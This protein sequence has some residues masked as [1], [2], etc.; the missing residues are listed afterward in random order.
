MSVVGVGVI[1]AI[2]SCIQK[3]NTSAPV[4]AY[5]GLHKRT[6]EDLTDWAWQIVLA[7]TATKNS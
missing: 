7:V 1:V 4:N 6:P 2:V 5:V 3:T